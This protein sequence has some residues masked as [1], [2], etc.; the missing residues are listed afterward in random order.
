MQ[1]KSNHPLLKSGR[2][3]NCEV[4]SYDTLQTCNAFHLSVGRCRLTWNSNETRHWLRDS[5]LTVEDVE[6]RDL[7]HQLILE[8]A[9]LLAWLYFIPKAP[10]TR[11]YGS[12]I[13]NIHL[14]VINHIPNAITAPHM[15]IYHVFYL[16]SILSSKYVFWAI[17]FT[18]GIEQSQATTI[19]VC[20]M[21]RPSSSKSGPRCIITVSNH[22]PKN[23]YAISKSVCAR[24]VYLNAFIT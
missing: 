6:R 15:I 14:I 12:K 16:R 5:P 10:G 21:N 9:L 18:F 23:K 1:R 17:L 11:V 2:N 13:F 19:D 7:V 24:E 20:V 8:T 3:Y 4:T 22:M